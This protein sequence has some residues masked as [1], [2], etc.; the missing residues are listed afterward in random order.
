[1]ARV[2]IITGKPKGKPRGK[3]F[4]SGGPSA[5]PTGRPPRNA[6]QRK[7][8]MDARLYAKEHGID[9]V[10]TQVMIMS[11][12]VVTRVLTASRSSRPRRRWRCWPRP[13]A[14]STEATAGRR[15][16][17]RFS[18]A[19]SDLRSAKEAPSKFSQ[20]SLL[21]CRSES[22]RLQLL[23]SLTDAQQQQLIYDWQFWGRN[24][25][26]MPPGDWFVWLIMT[27]RGWGKT[28]TAVEN[29]SRGAPK[30]LVP[31]TGRCAHS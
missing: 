31:D 5:N 13:T 3:P 30:L 19:T 16:R 6:Y 7:I 10:K 4:R 25:Q 27:G 12:L 2:K 9:A 14:S 17:W 15:K 23:S 8:E 28:R 22:E 18:V 21:S 20:A 24:D 29:I 1:M 11:G 26:Q